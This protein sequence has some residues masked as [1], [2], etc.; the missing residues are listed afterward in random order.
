[1]T[2][3]G[4]CSKILN[5]FLFLFTN[6][7]L[8]FR[9]G[10][11]KILVRIANRKDPDFLFVWFDDLHLSQQLWSFQDGQFTLPHFFSWASLTKQL[12]GAQLLSDRVLDSSRGATDSLGSLLCVLEQD[13]LILA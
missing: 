8:F 1:M 11:H 2:I 7:M 9:A 6:K 12:T 10:C 5:T 13:T 4:K 3:Y